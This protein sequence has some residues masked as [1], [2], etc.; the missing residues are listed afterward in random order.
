MMKV[1]VLDGHTPAGLETAQA[2]GRVGAEVH[3]AAPGDC[4]A[5]HSR[6]VHECL[7]Q[8]P[9]YNAHEFISWLRGLDARHHFALIV[10]SAEF[11]LLPF[12]T[13]AEDDSLRERA[14]LAPNRS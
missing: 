2:L 4:L 7:S 1:L 12:T 6:W 3:L 10:P 14:V 9:S 5:F 11:S 8:P 13:L